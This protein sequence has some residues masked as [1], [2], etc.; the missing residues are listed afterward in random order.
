MKLSQLISYVFISLVLINLA[1]DIIPHHHH[2]NSVFTHICCHDHSDAMVIISQD[3]P[4][5]YCHAFNGL[6][7]FPV[8]ENNKIAPLKFFS[9]DFNF[10]I[11][12]N[13]S[14]HLS[15][16]EGR[17]SRLDLPDLYRGL[18]RKVTSLR[19]PPVHG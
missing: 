13:A 5:S 14:I 2:T 1:H 15:I 10:L 3:E 16:Y 9:N 17:Y 11:S 18:D 19:A 6:E 12:S 7:Y 8:V 4:C